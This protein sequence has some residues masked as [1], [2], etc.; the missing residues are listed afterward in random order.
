[1]L[2]KSNQ[3][4]FLYLVNARV[5]QDGKLFLLEKAL[6]E[7]DRLLKVERDELTI[8]KLH[9]LQLD[10]ISKLC[11]II[12][13]FLY[14]HRVLRLNVRNIHKELLDNMTWWANSEAEFFCRSLTQREIKKTYHFPELSKFELN[15][16]DKQILKKAIKKN[17]IFHQKNLKEIG[18]FWIEH[19][20]IYNIFKHGCSIITG[21]VS[22]DDLYKP[23]HFYARTYERRRK[24][25]KTKRVKTYIVQC[26]DKFFN[27]Y[28]Y[29]R[30]QAQ[31]EFDSLLWSSEIALLNPDKD[32][33]PNLY[34]IDDKDEKKEIERILGK[35]SK[36][37]IS[38][39]TVKRIIEI[40]DNAFTKSK[41]KPNFYIRE[42]RR[43]IMF[44]SKAETESKIIKKKNK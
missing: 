38:P 27:S 34:G 8:Q 4:K 29:M 20:E 17:L 7:A 43:D 24:K 44:S 18:V 6:D 33:V 10:I 28:D 32:F 40:H 39:S 13:D 2:S 30:M 12:E 23:S 37:L 26:N 5:N 35:I 31:V 41:R 19:K 14:F 25:G 3:N 16:N 22:Q 36:D 1:M 9:F 42:M 11:T 21:M 15:K